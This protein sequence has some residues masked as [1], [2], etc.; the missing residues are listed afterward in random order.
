MTK[1]PANKSLTID[2]AGTTICLLADKAIYWPDKNCLLV[3]DIHLGKAGHFRKAG[4]PIPSTIHDADLKKL[5]GL[6]EIYAIEKVYLLGDLFHSNLNLEWLHFKN[7][8]KNF[9]D[10]QFVLIMGNH[11]ILGAKEYEATNF[12]HINKHLIVEPFLL[13]HSPILRKDIPEALFNLSGHI[14]PSIYLKGSSKQGMTL[15]CF[16][17]DTNYGILPAFGAFTGTA[18]VNAT[19]GS[20]IFAVAEDKIIPIKI[21]QLKKH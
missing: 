7:W 20:S 11:D 5:A 8:I 14:H 1:L 4:I 15:P 21:K 13:S 12:K 3:A 16:Y 9:K 17:F 6:I 18:N 10:T 2:I 19:N